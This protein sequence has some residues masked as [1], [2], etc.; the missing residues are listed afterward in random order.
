MYYWIHATRA[1]IWYY[2]YNH[3]VTV[4]YQQIYHP[5]IIRNPN[6]ETVDIR[7]RWLNNRVN[8]NCC[9]HVVYPGHLPILILISLGFA[10]LEA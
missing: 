6:V 5:I 7:V 2:N 3:P 4:C 9:T 8:I 10:S 1:G